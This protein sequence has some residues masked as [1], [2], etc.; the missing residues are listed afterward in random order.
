[1][2]DN[3]VREELLKRATL[4]RTTGLDVCSAA[5]DASADFKIVSVT[6]MTG[7]QAESVLL[8]TN[9]VSYSIVP[10]RCIVY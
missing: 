1:M 6:C 10:S 9:Q 7:K 3:E 8:S 2:K 5:V 4:S